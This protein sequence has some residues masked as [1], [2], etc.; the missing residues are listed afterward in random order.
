MA[1]TKRQMGNGERRRPNARRRYQTG[2]VKREQ[3]RGMANSNQGTEN[4]D[5]ETRNS[6]H[7]T[8][9]AIGKWGTAKNRKTGAT[10]S[11]KADRKN[12]AKAA[13]EGDRANA[14]K[15]WCALGLISI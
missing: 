13:T 1:I 3:Q 15:G 14:P 2:N 7:Q 4:G 10:A 5:C 8:R 9:M 6:K 11:N 12:G